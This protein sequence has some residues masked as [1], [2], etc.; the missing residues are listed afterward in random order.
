MAGFRSGS[1]VK[2]LDECFFDSPIIHV[3]LSSLAK[4][5]ADSGRRRR[6]TG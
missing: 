6:G 5:H 2:N 4:L 3:T 1:F